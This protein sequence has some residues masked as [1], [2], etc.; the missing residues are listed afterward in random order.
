MT[1]DHI[2]NEIHSDMM[3]IEDLV[4]HSLRGC[5]LNQGNLNVPDQVAPHP[6]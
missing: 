6:S 5:G 2:H 1:F 3:G 4:I